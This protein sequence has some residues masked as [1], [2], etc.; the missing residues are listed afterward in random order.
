[1]SGAAYYMRLDELIEVVGD[2]AA[3]KLVAAMGGSR[4]YVR[5]RMDAGSPIAEAIG[6]EAAQ[7]LA[8]HI[9][10]GIGGLV[11]EIPMG[12]SSRTAQYRTRLLER[13]RSSNLSERDIARE[14]GVH[15][16][17]VRRARRLLRAK[18]SDDDQGSLF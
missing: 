18:A 9:A 6:L 3:L 12:P 4:F 11:V 16:R 15:G 10:T 13:V 14:M 7:I 1:M 5:E 8:A 17:T 2:P